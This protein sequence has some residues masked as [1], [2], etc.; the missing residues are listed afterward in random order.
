MVVVAVSDELGVQR[1]LYRGG[2]H[3]QDALWPEMFVILLAVQTDGH[4]VAQRLWIIQCSNSL[5]FA[6]VEVM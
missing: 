6:C 4:F 5:L 1:A 2:L 3:T